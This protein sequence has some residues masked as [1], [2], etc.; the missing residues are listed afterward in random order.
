MINQ[1]LQLLLQILTHL[2]SQLLFPASF[3]LFFLLNESSQLP[4][5]QVL[6]SKLQSFWLLFH[7]LLS[8]VCPFPTY[9]GLLL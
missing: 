8:K 1:Y 7:T 3:S 6:P 9:Q 4:K 2:L 5:P